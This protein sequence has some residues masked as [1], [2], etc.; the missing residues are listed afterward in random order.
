VG[1]RPELSRRRF[2]A[3]ATVAAAQ[4]GA[5]ALGGPALARSVIGPPTPTVPPIAAR[6]A[7]KR[8]LPP[9]PR[10]IHNGPTDKA[11][12]A[13][14]IDD[15]WGNFGA[16]N[17]NA[18]MDVA[19]AK[20]VKLTFFPTGGAIEEHIGLGRQEVW[21]RA[22]SEG[23][24]IG[25]HTYTHANLARSSDDKIRFEMQHSK[26]LLEQCLGPSYP[27]TMRLMRP[28]GGG[29]GFVT[30][31]DPRVMNVI[32]SF[33]YSMTMWTV[34]ANGVKGNSAFV[35]K[36]MAGA[37][38]GTIVLIHFT[39]FTP[40]GFPTLIDRLRNERKLEPTTVTGLF[41]P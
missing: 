33:D 23:H 34:D 22:I 8:L 37:G 21:R 28:P 13:I 35:N 15:M 17:A 3:G 7:L 10:W 5:L 25:N 32:S 30:G 24:E 16:D 14:T 4:L 6:H 31:G 40:D 39:E 19:K 29:G 26:D 41:N 9:L 2:F 36:V 27:Y 18:A 1:D 38:N 20:N 12:V 11:R